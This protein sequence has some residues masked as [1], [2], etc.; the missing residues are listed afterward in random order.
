MAIPDDLLDA[1]MKDYK[2]P[3]DLIGETGLLKQL[4]KQLCQPDDIPILE[5]RQVDRR[6]PAIRLMKQALQTLLHAEQVAHRIPR[7]RSILPEKERGA[8][9]PFLPRGGAR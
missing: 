8:G 5:L 7:H 4:T 2:N 3:E 1:L 6:H 9:R